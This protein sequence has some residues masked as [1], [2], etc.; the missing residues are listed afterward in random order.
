MKSSTQKKTGS[1]RVERKDL[2]S[3]A[4]YGQSEACGSGATGR[5]FS[6]STMDDGLPW[7]RDVQDV[8]RCANAALYRS[9]NRCLI[10]SIKECLMF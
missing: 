3:T 9:L 7:W 8:V 4:T 10:E 2:S 6:Y 5:H 1:L